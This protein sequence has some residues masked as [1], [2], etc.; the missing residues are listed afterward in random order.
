MEKILQ[1]FKSV[2]ANNPDHPVT[3]T[4]NADNPE[5]MKFIEYLAEHR[6]LIQH[7]GKIIF[8]PYGKN[9]DRFVCGIARMWKEYKDRKSFEYY[10]TNSE[11]MREL[12][13]NEKGEDNKLAP[14]YTDIE[15]VKYIVTWE[16]KDDT[17]IFHYNVANSNERGLLDMLWSIF[18]GI[19]TKGNKDELKQLNPQI[20]VNFE[21]A[22]SKDYGYNLGLTKMIYEHAHSLG[23]AVGG[24]ISMTI[25]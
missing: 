12:F 13:C 25:G 10:Y 16:S 21:I 22:L 3:F 7:N 20:G 18:G 4:L 11:M 8:A 23:Y 2:L 5:S 24:N 19:T 15:G 9:I 6:T 1:T 14:I 17:D